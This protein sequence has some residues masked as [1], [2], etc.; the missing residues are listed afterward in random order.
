MWIRV[1]GKTLIHK[2]WIKN[3][4]FLNPSLN[5]FRPYLEVFIDVFLMNTKIKADT[6]LTVVMR[7]HVA[8]ISAA[9]RC[10]SRPIEKIRITF[11]LVN[12]F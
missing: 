7:R 9:D 8:A 12:C 5:M 3:T 2:M 1:G 11:F 10:R 4:F 6:N